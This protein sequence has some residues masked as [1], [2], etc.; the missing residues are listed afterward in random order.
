[1]TTWRVAQCPQQ[2]A[3]VFPAALRL[4]MSVQIQT[5]P[6]QSLART[7]GGGVNTLHAPD[8]NQQSTRRPFPGRSAIID[9]GYFALHILHKCGLALPSS[10][11]LLHRFRRFLFLALR[12]SNR[13]GAI[14]FRLCGMSLLRLEVLTRGL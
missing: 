7:D 8:Q 5:A 6:W 12:L 11:S 2:T 10:C 1:M 13:R 4:A 3:P 14:V 9:F